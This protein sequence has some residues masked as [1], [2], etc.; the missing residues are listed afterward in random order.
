MGILAFILIVVIAVAC[1]WIV[2]RDERS[3]AA[4]LAMLGVVSFACVVLAGHLL[5]TLA[6]ATESPLVGPWSFV[7]VLAAALCT[8]WAASGRRLRQDVP[9]CV[10]C[11]T[12]TADAD[13]KGYRVDEILRGELS[14]SPA[15][16]FLVV[17]GLLSLGSGLV[18]G[19]SGPPRGWDVLSY[20][21]PRAVAWLQ[22]G[23]LG[24]YGFSP[25]FYPGNG[26]VLDLITLFSGTDRLATIVQ[27]PFALIGAVSLYGLARE[28]GARRESALLVPAAFALTPMVVFQSGI[29]KN[30]LVVAGTVLAGIYLLVLALRRPAFSKERR[31]ALALGGLSF[32]LALG[33][34][35]T[36]LPF[37]VATVPVAFLA[38]LLLGDRAK[39]SA[40]PEDPSGNPLPCRVCWRLAVPETAIFVAGL[41]IPSAFWFAQNWIM[42][43]NPVAPI[44]V[45][46]GD[47]KV[48][49]GLDVATEFGEQEFRY[50]SSP[51]Q[52]LAWP[53]LERT[54]VGA[55]GQSVGYGA[56]FATFFVPALVL[57]VRRVFA[58]ARDSG[59]RA[60]PLVLV[61]CL[62]GAACWWQGGFRMPRY[63]WPTLA[64][65]LAP[66]A[67]LFDVMKGRARNILMSMLL[68]AATFSFLETERI[69]FD[70]TSL[71]SSRLPGWMTKQAYYSMPDLIYELPSGTRVLLLQVPGEAYHRTFRYPLVG[72]LPGNDVIMLDDVGVDLADAMVDT[73]LMHVALR[74]ER[75][76]YIFERTLQ[77][78]PGP[79]V[80]DSF[81]NRY[82]KVVGTIGR[83]YGWHRSG[84][85]GVT[86][87]GRRVRFPVVTNIYRVLY[88]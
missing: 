12:G 35:Y 71:V 63:L 49:R 84:I 47:M 3:R 46:L 7:L 74:R 37:V 13:G 86:K 77:S 41:L 79:T 59:K 75:V 66:A 33:T 31:L 57:L 52:W 36:I 67:L 14:R 21:L 54:I 78:Q 55:Y 2:V 53:W 62:L 70:T 42:A 88:Q 5:G 1:A 87:D 16:S 43:G 48:F 68:V 15:L 45:S 76:E 64:V 50:V 69:I 58:G 19:L 34:K 81:P 20:H 29:A 72:D 28:L 83:P 22:H 60:A 17:L 11:A 85:A 27:F 44:S 39:R 82:E 23:N 25:A 38:S 18:L 9:S 4:R 32:G 80:F 40:R 65:L 26:E 30:D 56:V 24:L 73:A 8:L 61:L 10:W 6:A 51:L